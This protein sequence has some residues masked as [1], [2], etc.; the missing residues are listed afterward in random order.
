MC[1]ERRRAEVMVGIPRARRD[2]PAM[3]DKAL[4]DEIRALYAEVGRAYRVPWTFDFL[5]FLLILL[6]AVFCI[7]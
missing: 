6:L 5:V 2:E 3:A 7:G 1:A 4:Y